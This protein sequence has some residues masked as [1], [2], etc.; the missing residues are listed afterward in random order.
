MSSRPRVLVLQPILDP[1]GGGEVV[2]AATVAALKDEYD[3]TLLSL[4]TI[5]WSAVA[6][7]T[8]YRIEPGGV[9]VRVVSRFAGWRLPAIELA[10]LQRSILLHHARRMLDQY[11]LAISV[12]NEIDTGRRSIQYIHFPW[13]YWPRP[14]ADLRWFHRIA[15]VLPAYYRMADAI[16]H[17]SPEAIA[18]NR[19]L[20][21]S[22]WTGEK[23]RQRYGGET[24]TLYPPVDAASPVPWSDR[25]DTFVIAGRF[26]RGK[27]IEAAL[28]IVER[29]RSGGHDVRLQAIGTIVDRAYA[30]EI[31]KWIAHRHW[32][33]LHVNVSR[34]ELLALLSR[35]RY[36][37]HAMHDEHFGM[38]PAEM[39]A[40]GCI[41]FVPRGGGQ[42]EIAGG[43]AR[44]VYDSDDDAVAKIS[45]VLSSAAMKPELQRLLLT[46]ARGFAPD[47][48]RARMRTIVAEELARASRRAT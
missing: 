29:V 36:G 28:R 25:Q 14:D 42:M 41:V 48:F 8:G 27:R 31:R 39:A 11:D 12:N 35:A 22:D 30:R 9:D 32:A 20:V 46:R 13:G 21:N 40:S 6:R 23:F 19:T 18:R 34:D 24:T 17:V 47:R 10:L 4:R 15:G 3:V 7:F 33:S 37:L 16:A 44:L 45:A 43:D 26:F 1:R 5:D 2:A 38:A